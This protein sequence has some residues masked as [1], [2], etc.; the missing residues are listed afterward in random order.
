[1]TG[2]EKEL[3]SLLNILNSTRY[4]VISV[5]PLSDNVFQT[6]YQTA[7]IDIISIDPSKYLPNAFWK[8]LKSAANR[9]IVVEILYTHFMY[10]ETRQRFFSAAENIIF[11]MRARQIVLSNGST[12]RFD[13]RTPSD[14]RN[15]ASLIKIK[16]PQTI[17]STLPK[18][19]IAQG[20]SR[21]THAGVVRR[22][23]I[24][25]EEEEEEIEIQLVPV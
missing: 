25:V 21:Q 17:T 16:H 22:K 10:P 7:N 2:N 13:I 8:S 15:L 3:Q 4:N 20:M 6:C 19:V 11:R 18:T 12:N 23:V 24:P 14:V 5:T 1:M 9:G